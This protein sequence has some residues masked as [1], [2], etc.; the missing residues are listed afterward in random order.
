M[1]GLSNEEI[2]EKRNEVVEKLRNDYHYEDV[3]I[4]NNYFPGLFEKINAL[5]LLGQSICLLSQA[6]VAY[7]C[8]GWDNYRGCSIEHLCAQSYGIKTIEEVDD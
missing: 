3:E 4:I 1:N 6:D 8:K 7:F 2:T 5:W